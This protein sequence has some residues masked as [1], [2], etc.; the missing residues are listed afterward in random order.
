[1][2]HVLRGFAWLGKVGGFNGEEESDWSGWLRQ[3]AA[4]HH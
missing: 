3:D 4:V 2:N 1:M